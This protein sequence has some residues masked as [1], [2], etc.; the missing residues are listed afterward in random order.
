MLFKLRQ[1]VAVILAGLLYMSSEQ[2]GAACLVGQNC[3][4]RYIYIIHHTTIHA[5]NSINA[6]RS[7]LLVLLK[8]D[9]KT[10]AEHQQPTAASR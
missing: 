3:R 2:G 5:L 6:T 7:A 10:T 8:A 9:L 4:D 1:C